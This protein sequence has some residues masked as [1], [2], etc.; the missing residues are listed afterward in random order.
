[1]PHTRGVQ[2]RPLAQWEESSLASIVRLW[3]VGAPG[4]ARAPE[5][6]TVNQTVLLTTDRGRFVLRG[7]RHQNIEPIERE[8]AVIAYA[9][10]A[11]LPAVAPLPLPS[12]A[13]VYEENGKYY[14]LFPWAAGR[15]VRRADIETRHAAAMGLC[16]ARLHV[17]LATFPVDRHPFPR[18]WVPLDRGDILARMDELEARMRAALTTDALA[19]TALARV[20]GQR[21]YLEGLPDGVL[22]HYQSPLAEQV[23]HGDYQEANLFFAGGAV[24]AVTAIIDWDQTRLAPPAAEV[25]RIFDLVF[26]FEPERCRR[27][28]RE[29]RRV[30]P[31]SLGDLDAAAAAYDVRVSHGLWVYEELYLRGNRRVARFIAGSGG[32]VPISERWASVRDACG[33]ESV[34]SGAASLSTGALKAR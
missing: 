22:G 25:V 30:R 24:T 14:S 12:G 32:F 27:F 15:Q 16:L 26:D 34:W 21:M 8:H 29:Y 10:A 7:Y 17:A 6:G 28:L 9:R 4:D 3:G 13:T 23:I 31:L 19:P 20:L 2:P 5:T 33:S 18:Y 11:G 1:M